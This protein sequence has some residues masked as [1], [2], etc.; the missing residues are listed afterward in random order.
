[1][2]AVLQSA[3]RLGWEEARLHFEFFQAEPVLADGD[4]AF[5]VRLARSGK[6]VQVG[7]QQS[8]LHALLAAGVEVPTS[9]EQG[10]CGTCVTRVLEGTPDHRDS[11][12]MPEE[13]AAN[14][15]F[16]PCCSRAR[17]PW[18]VLDL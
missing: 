10:I 4:R 8:V 9:C 2:D 5:S 7:A 18:L 12:L 15:C 3:R 13:H 17:S 14:R 6:T 16:M 1:M 11:F